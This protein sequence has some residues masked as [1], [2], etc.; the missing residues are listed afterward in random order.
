MLVMFFLRKIKNKRNGKQKTDKKAKALCS[1]VAPGIAVVL[2]THRY[3][4]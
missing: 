4:G 3:V 1:F 2:R